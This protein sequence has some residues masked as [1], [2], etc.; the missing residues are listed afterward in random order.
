MRAGRRRARRIPTANPT[1][2]RTAK[3]AVSSLGI[4]CPT[5]Y[6]S[7]PGDSGGSFGEPVG[8]ARLSQMC[9]EIASTAAPAGIIVRR[10]RRRRS[11]AGPA[12]AAMASAGSKV[13]V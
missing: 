6:T 3:A 1:S 7:D 12:T 9:G 5:T 8:W 2:A 11:S 4:I 10:S 13:S